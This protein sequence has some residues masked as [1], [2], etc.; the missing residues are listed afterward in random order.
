MKDFEIIRKIRRKDA[1][2]VIEGQKNGSLFSR[3]WDFL[4]KPG[5]QKPSVYYPNAL[6]STAS[7]LEFTGEGGVTRYFQYYPSEAQ[8][9]SAWDGEEE[10]YSY[11][12]A[13]EKI[14]P[15]G[16]GRDSR[17]KRVKEVKQCPEGKIDFEVIPEQPELVVRITRFLIQD[18]KQSMDL[19]EHKEIAENIKKQKLV[20]PDE[21]NLYFGVRVSETNRI[22]KKQTIKTAAQKV[23]KLCTIMPHGGVDLFDF[24]E[25]YKNKCAK[26]I[27][28]FSRYLL[29]WRD[30]LS[31]AKDIITNL[32]KLH[33]AGYIHGDLKDINILIKI[34]HT[35]IGKEALKIDKIRIID[36]DGAQ[37]IKGQGWFG[38]TTVG[39]RAPEVKRS[40]E[41]PIYYRNSI[42]ELKEEKYKNTFIYV[43]EEKNL[44]L[45]F[46]D[47]KLTRAEIKIDTADQRKI[48]KIIERYTSD[49]QKYPEPPLPDLIEKWNKEDY[50]CI[51]KPIKN[52]KHCEPLTFL[53]SIDVYSLGVVLKKLYSKMVG[54]EAEKSLEV[55]SIAALKKQFEAMTADNPEDRPALDDSMAFFDKELDKVNSQLKLS[56][57]NLKTASTQEN[58]QQ[59]LEEQ[60]LPISE[61][62]LS[63]VATSLFEISKR[64]K[65]LDKTPDEIKVLNEVTRLEI[66]WLDKLTDELL[67]FTAAKGDSIDIPKIVKELGIPAVTEK[68]LAL[69]KK[70]KDLDQVAQV[71]EKSIPP[72]AAVVQPSQEPRSPIGWGQ[73]ILLSFRNIIS[74]C[75]GF[76]HRLGSLFRGRPTQMSAQDH[77][78]EI[79]TAIPP[80]RQ[81]SPEKSADQKARK[82]ALG[83]QRTFQFQGR[84]HGR[85]TMR[86]FPVHQPISHSQPKVRAAKIC[87]PHRKVSI[88]REEQEIRREYN[89]SY[90]ETLPMSQDD[91]QLNKK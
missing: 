11:D 73:R 45:Y 25:I 55:G 61:L 33:E 27:K 24:A 60:K 5:A 70:L 4:A 17:V 78:L 22:N 6:P 75:G 36:L 87:Q 84:V 81:I 41:F 18:Y 35:K 3:L 10:K 71:E 7:I 16:E 59:I 65:E 90:S 86:F 40:R 15:I 58:F 43:K 49:F 37:K 79:K 74:I 21:K 69:L 80:N 57:E 88:F 91:F 42:E 48:T 44:K 31:V 28:L 83:S 62:T 89:V 68:T 29:R 72:Q 51:V 30:F 77:K 12:P 23:V 39:Y 13:Y 47:E 9:Q 1:P 26:G 85:D 34:S 82:P 52:V 54:E 2:V 19:L 32:K 63:K 46:L 64:R 38:A 53:P 20:F 14:D 56:H 66:R 76:F 67:T 8:R 50:D